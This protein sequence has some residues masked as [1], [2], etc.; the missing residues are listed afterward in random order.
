M[1][2]SSGEELGPLVE[3][4]AEKTIG[5]IEK[6]G[7]KLVAPSI[8]KRDRIA[9]LK[10]ALGEAKRPVVLVKIVERHVGR[11]TVDP[12]AQTELALLCRE[13]GFEVIDSKA[14]A[15]RKA[16]VI[17]EGEA[18]SEFAL[19][20]GDLVCVKARLELTARESGTG[21]VVAVDRQTEVVVDLTELLAG[22]AAL[23]E[24]AASI[25]ERL[26]PKL[27]AKTGK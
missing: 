8:D 22:K 4:L 16:D 20:Q 11:E 14:A 19:R 18:I 23:Q 27:V 3:K 10:R 2:G 7:D 13:T 25:A 21:R 5:T 26:L 24:A 6:G 17:I 9:D 1:K 12:A 15:T